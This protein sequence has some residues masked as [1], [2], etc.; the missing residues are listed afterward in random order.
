MAP[1]GAGHLSRFTELSADAQDAVLSGL[2][3][4]D[5]ELLRAGFQA[6]KAL[7]MMALYRLP[8]SWPAIGYDGPV[9]KWNE[10]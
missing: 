8:K 9:V 10:P 4:S 2:E 6:L 1:L 3:A 5:I 7:A